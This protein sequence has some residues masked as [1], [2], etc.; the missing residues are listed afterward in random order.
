MG[1]RRKLADRRALDEAKAKC[2]TSRLA[3]EREP[4]VGLC[5]HVPIL[6][7][8]VLKGDSRIE[9]VETK[10]VGEGRLVGHPSLRRRRTLLSSPTN[11]RLADLDRGDVV[12]A[13]RGSPEWQRLPQLM[14][15]RRLANARMPHSMWQ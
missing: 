6:F 5:S 11:D 7:L 8:S 1:K 9:V 4:V 10:V 15:G 13:T 12:E 2:R 3:G 14:R